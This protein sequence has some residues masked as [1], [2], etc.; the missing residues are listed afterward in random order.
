MR[1]TPTC[2]LI[3]LD[4][5]CL[6]QDSKRKNFMANNKCML[7]NNILDTIIAKNNLE[8]YAPGL[9]AAE[10][11]AARAGW[12]S[13][14]GDGSRALGVSPPSLPRPRALRRAS[15]SASPELDNWKDVA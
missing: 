3:V 12:G 10:E 7:R 1:P 9:V 2:T 4:Y 5:K 6:I 13:K 8:Y 14:A 15:P 11:R